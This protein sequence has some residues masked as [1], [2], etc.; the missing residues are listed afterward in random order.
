MPIWGLTLIGDCVLFLAPLIY[1]TNKEFIDEH[2]RSASATINEQ[3]AQVKDLTASYT[4]QA[5]ETVKAYAGE[6]TAKAQDLMGMNEHRNR[7]KIDASDFPSAPKTELNTA[8]TSGSDAKPVA[9]IPT[10]AM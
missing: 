2:L 5:T 7:Q 3:A 4:G 9:A 1:V 8:T 10:P 6:Y